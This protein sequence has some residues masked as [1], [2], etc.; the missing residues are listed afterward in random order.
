MSPRNELDEYIETNLG[1][2]FPKGNDARTLYHYTTVDTFEVMTRRDAD[3]ICT[4]CAAMN[5]SAEFSIG[6]KLIRDY[7][8]RHPGTMDAEMGTALGKLSQNPS[9]ASWSMSFSRDGD[10]LNQWISYTD[11]KDG[12]VAIGFDLDDLNRRVHAL[13][14]KRGLMYIVPCLYVGENDKDIEALLNYLFSTYRETLMTATRGRGRRGKDGSLK[15][16]SLIIA[17]IF[18]SMVKDG[19]FKGEHEWRLVMLPCDTDVRDCEFIAGKPRLRTRLFGDEYE[20]AEH[21]VDV[22]CSPHGHQQHRAEMIASL[23]RLGFTPQRSK[24][25]YNV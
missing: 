24:S 1:H 18:A 3:F 5:D 13:K 12:G 17:L 9:F 10:S 22:V 8:R 15:E 6:I 21:I 20:L 16:V 7:M 11:R 2:L 14:N 4:Y 19:S 25:T 23:R